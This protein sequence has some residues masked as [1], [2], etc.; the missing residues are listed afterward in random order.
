MRRHQFELPL[1]SRI[2]RIKLYCVDSLD[3]DTLVGQVAAHR[4]AGPPA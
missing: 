3:A 4:G 2:D 1:G